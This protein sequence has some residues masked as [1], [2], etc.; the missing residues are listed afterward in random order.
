MDVDGDKLS[1]HSRK[2]IN[3][4][5]SGAKINDISDDVRDFCIEN[6]G[7][8]DCVDKVIVCLG[9]NDI[10]FFNGQKYDVFKRFMSPLT[11]LVNLIKF[12]LPKAQVILKC[13]LP[14][15]TFYNYTAYTVHE[16][17]Y[18]LLDICRKNSCIFF[19]CF[20]RFLDNYGYGVD[21][22]LY[23][24]K[25]HLNGEGLKVLCRALKFAIYKDIFNPIMR[26]N[27]TNYTYLDWYETNFY[28]H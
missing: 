14:M 10:K 18:L 3:C 12:V 24:D 1:R 26:I 23:R 11:R 8:T 22:Y 13:V 5:T 9:T 4:S 6:P 16:F 28:Y 17:N 27:S 2:V 25:W 21:E 19:D 20:D 15:K 7:I